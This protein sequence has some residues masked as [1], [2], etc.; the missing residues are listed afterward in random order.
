M[1]GSY[2]TASL[3]IGAAAGPVA[4]AATLPTPLGDRGPFWTAAVLVAVSL[5][6]ASAFRE[7]VAPGAAP[8]P[9][10]ESVHV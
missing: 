9:A 6:A 7:V 5:F 1:A 10:G 2:A 8:A 4:A 3:N